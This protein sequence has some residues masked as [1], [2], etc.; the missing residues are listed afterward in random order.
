MN[1]R[2][3]LLLYTS[4]EDAL[5]IRERAALEHRTVSGYVLNILLRTVAFE[6]TLDAWLGRRGTCLSSPPAI[7]LPGPKTTM[8]LRCSSEQAQRIRAAARRRAVNVSAYIRQALWRSWKSQDSVVAHVRPVL[9]D[10][11]AIPQFRKEE[12]TW[13]PLAPFDRGLNGYV[14][15]GGEE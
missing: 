15:G 10:G 2:T 9:L 6:E 13:V 4:Q 12:R 1:Q 8:L 3:A 14:T 11:E 7:C 5:K